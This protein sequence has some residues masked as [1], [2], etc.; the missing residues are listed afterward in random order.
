MKTITILCALTAAIFFQGCAS[1]PGGDEGVSASVSA[2]DLNA[3]ALRALN[4]LYAKNDKARQMGPA[5]AGILVFPDIVKAGFLG[6]GAFGYGVL[7]EHGQPT[8][9]YSMAAGSYGFQAGIQKFGFA[10][11]LI[12]AKGLAA[13]HKLGGWNF[14][15]SPEIVVVDKGIARSLSIATL[16]GGTYAFFF[17]QSGLMGGIG[18]EGSKITRIY[19]TRP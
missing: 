13:L 10:L 18:L 12:D 5:A 7:F 15:G 8:G 2:S 1:G 3:K 6:A 9:Y 11:M 4:N 14:G 19:P 16:E 17:N